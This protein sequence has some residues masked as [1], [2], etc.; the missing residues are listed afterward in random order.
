MACLLLSAC[1]AV[2]AATAIPGGSEA[3]TP[4]GSTPS[5][6][7]AEPSADADPLAACDGVEPD[8]RSVVVEVGTVSWAFDTERIEGPRHCQPFVIEFTNSDVAL[9]GGMMGGTYEHNI[10]IRLGGLLG[11]LVFEGDAIG[12][13]TIRYEIPGLPSGT[14]FFYCALHAEVMRGDLVVAES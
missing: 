8:G 12:T 6:V 11:P 13:T 14:H 7:E 1:G 2:P 3:A 9:A 5:A 10:F 4:T